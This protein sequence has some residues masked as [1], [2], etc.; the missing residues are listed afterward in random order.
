MNRARSS[1]PP[2]PDDGEEIVLSDGDAGEDYLEESE[3]DDGPV[4]AALESVPGHLTVTSLRGALKDTQLVLQQVYDKYKDLKIDYDALLHDS[5]SSK[6]KLAKGKGNSM[7]TQDQQIKY[8]ASRFSITEQL[9]MDKSILDLP[10]PNTI[11]DR[12]LPLDLDDYEGRARRTISAL[13]EDLSSNLREALALPDRRQSFKRIFMLQFGQERS[14]FVTRSREGAAIV[15]GLTADSF[16]A[17]ADHSMLKQEVIDFL[18]DPK[19]PGEVC[20]EWP[21]VL[22]PKD[23]P[24][25]PL[26]FRSDICVKFLRY[27]LTLD[28]GDDAP[29]ESKD[30]SADASANA[31]NEA[32]KSKSKPKPLPKRR[33]VNQAGATLLLFVCG[34]DG[35]FGN[36]STGPSGVNWEERYEIYKDVILR[37]PEPFRCDLLE[38][39][40]KAIF[41]KSPKASNGHSGSDEPARGVAR[42]NEILAQ[43]YR[44][45]SRPLSES[46]PTLPQHP[47]PVSI[48]AAFILEDC[49]ATPASSPAPT[50]IDPL[51]EMP[52]IVMAP[53]TARASSAGPR[54][55]KPVTSVAS[56]SAPP[57][58]APPV[59]IEESESEVP[60]PKGSRLTRRNQSQKPK[61]GAVSTATM[62]TRSRAR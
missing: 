47:R 55:A 26:P 35:S 6:A 16:K 37:M 27:I 40:N 58:V 22:F 62:A 5:R 2:G 46:P 43:M 15:F 8:A 36:Q 57:S 17:R 3:F 19:N 41:D 14:N 59:L 51:D 13:Y 33:L 7:A 53:P 56:R 38:M 10:R 50:D 4:R 23:S 28:S 25:S 49:H 54:T 60:I 45:N 18:E 29:A 24:N 48:E 42:S 9:F 39:Y 21:R 34:P 11:V 30:A 61:Q 12:S 32:K 1:N 31:S 52:M 44:M 20:P